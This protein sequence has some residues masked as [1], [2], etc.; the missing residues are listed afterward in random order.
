M[1]EVSPRA[2]DGGSVADS[3]A[4]QPESEA[5][6]SD[7]VWELQLRPNGA[8]NVI[9]SRLLI[10]AG[11]LLLIA[12]HTVAT[13]L[14]LRDAWWWQDDFNILGQAAGQPFG[15]DLLLRAYNG[16]LQPATWLMAW[17]V[18]HVSPPY[19][20]WM[21]AAVQTIL[22]VATDLACYVLLRRL[23]GARP[24]IL[25]PLAAF[26]ASAITLTAT[27]WWAAALQWLPVSL[28]LALALLCHVNYLDGGRRRSAVGA[29]AAVAG[30]LFCF[31]KALTVLP[32]LVL[33]SLLY[34]TPGPWWKRPLV[35]LR[36]TPVYWAA[37]VALGFGWLLLYRAQ[38]TGAPTP[39]TSFGDAVELGRQLV[40]YTV[41]PGILGGPIDWFG[42]AG[43]IVSW[44]AP[45]AAIRNL[46]WAVAAVV[47]LG[48]L[49]LR[50]GAWRAWLIL[51]LY[52]GLTVILVAQTR[53]AVFGPTIG[54]DLRYSTDLALLTPLCAALAWLPLRLRQTPARPEK[55]NEQVDAEQDAHQRDTDVVRVWTNQRPGILIAGALA[56]VLVTAGGLISGARFMTMWQTNPAE[57]YV[58]HL[59]DGLAQGTPVTLFD[60]RVPPHV[61]IPEF[62]KAAQLSW[63]TRPLDRRPRFVTSAADVQMVDDTGQI[64]PAK[65]EGVGSELNRP[66][67]GRR[68]VTVPLTSSVLA[69]AWIAQI[70]YTSTNP[71]PAVVSLDTGTARIALEPGE[72][73]IFAAIIGGGA[74]V[75]VTGMDANARVCVSRV[76]IGNLAPR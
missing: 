50:R 49:A 18:T 30:G 29:V 15:L 31:E 4:T 64:R 56:V 72:H 48:S 68:H 75:T 43:S 47:L 42:P 69:W 70:S 44:P 3:G 6:H 8:I 59:R 25:V 27:L 2:A 10:T 21:A 5:L 19:A 35:A 1:H 11:A 12:I 7:V 9:S 58:N 36:R 46:T 38:V 34:L 54:R 66:I 13:V 14:R 57:T 67:C 62:G 65:V 23:F 60:Q 52:V 32:V 33:F 41:I 20:W 73:E 61:M 28:S 71:T 40:L 55:Q 74:S 39:S 45:P 51:G 24:A 63:I 53:G 37:Q 17:A 22:V 26:C 16:H 76:V